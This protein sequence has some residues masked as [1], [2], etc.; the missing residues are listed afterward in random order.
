MYTSTYLTKHVHPSSYSRSPQT[1]HPPLAMLENVLQLSRK[2]VILLV[3]LCGLSDRLD[4][5]LR[6]T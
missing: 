5:R 3:N 1:P 4:G 6:C 2:G